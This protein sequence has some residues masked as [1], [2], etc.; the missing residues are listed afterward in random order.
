MYFYTNAYYSSRWY[1]DDATQSSWG[2]EWGSG[3]DKFKLRR[4]PAGSTTFADFLVVNSLGKVGIGT[5]TPTYELAVNGT[6][7]CKQLIVDTNWSDFVF[8]DDYKLPQLNAVEQFIKENKH[9]PGI[10]S[11]AHVKQDGVDVGEIS[12]KLLQKIEELTLYLIDIKK[13]NDFIK[14]QL[15]NLET[16]LQEIKD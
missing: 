8:Y 3:T 13:E 16:Q 4:A 15:A 5:L 14:S 12:S 10:P 1:T 2:I 7:R 11:E 6:I 9:L